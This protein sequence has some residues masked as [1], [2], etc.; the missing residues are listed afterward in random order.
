MLVRRRDAVSPN[1]TK[2]KMM[3]WDDVEK[4]SDEQETGGQYLKLAGDGDSAVVVFV[5]EPYARQRVWSD[6]DGRYVTYE[7]GVHDPSKKKL[8]MAMN[9]Y[10]LKANGNLRKVRAKY[11]LDKW[12]FE[13]QRSGAKGDMQT[14]YSIL[15]EEQID[16]ELRQTINSAQLYDLEEM[17]SDGSTAPPK[18]S[19]APPRERRAPSSTANEYQQHDD[20]IPF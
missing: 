15:P 8:S 5:G 7:P 17:F 9:V 4:L 11:G 19:T 13:I 20:E 16:A 6:T 12:S 3:G 10:V 2:E 14:K 1:Q 18:D